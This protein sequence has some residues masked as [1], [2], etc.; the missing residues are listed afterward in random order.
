MCSV[1]KILTEN[2]VFPA[3]RAVDT[4]QATTLLQ[5]EEESW[6]EEILE[7]EPQ[8]YILA[9]PKSLANH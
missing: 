3:E 2:P 1:T 9:L 8:I 6:K 5:S 4:F 7:L